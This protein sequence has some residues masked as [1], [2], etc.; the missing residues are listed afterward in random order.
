MEEKQSKSDSFVQFFKDTSVEP[1]EVN[2]ILETKNS[3]LVK[4]NDK[5][6]KLFARPNITM[7]DM[8]QVDS[9]DAYI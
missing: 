2:P 8:R 3:A 9:V 7:D 1:K 4:Q 6:F 5:M